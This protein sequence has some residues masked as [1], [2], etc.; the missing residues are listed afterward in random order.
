MQEATMTGFEQVFSSGRT[1]PILIRAID[2][3]GAHRYLVA[4]ITGKEFDKGALTRELVAS[5]LASYFGLETPEPVLLKVPHNFT[6]LGLPPAV[7]R[8]IEGGFF[9]TFATEYIAS[10][11]AF[12]PSRIL[13]ERNLPLAAEIFA[14]DALIVN[15]DRSEDGSVNCLT[16]SNRFVLI[17]H[18][19]A[20][21]GQLIGS[22][23]YMEPWKV[24]SLGPMRNVVKHIFYDSLD[25][26]G[27]SFADARAKWMAL[28][29]HE[30][31]KMLGDVPTVW[32]A[33]DRAL[34]AIRGYLTNLLE[35]LDAAFD[36]VEGVLQ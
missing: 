25:G 17:D 35:N 21:D 36:E 13:H 12:V 23:I 15:R 30:I 7:E 1:K 31:D 32:E 14:F 9:P 28:S 3:D 29:V 16:D 4:K 20:L 24:G 6:E 22:S 34:R 8:A 27:V 2:R 33:E 11:S 18:E 10:L 5:K 26:T 19:T